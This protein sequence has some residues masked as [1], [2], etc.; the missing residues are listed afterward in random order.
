MRPLVLFDYD[1]VLVDSLDYFI[2]AFLDACHEHGCHQVRTR[3]DFLNLFDINFYDGMAKVGLTG[4][5]R[6]AVYRGMAERLKMKSGKYSFFKGIPEALREAAEFAD[7]YVI[8]SNDSRVVQEFLDA[9]N[10]SLYR[11][12][13]GA[14]KD[15]SK[16]RKIRGVS[17]RHPNVPAIYVGDTT[18]DILEARE[19]G[20]ISVGVAWGWHGLARLE[21]IRP[22]HLLKTPADLVPCLRTFISALPLTG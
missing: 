8:S 14:D 4:K 13:L 11:E 5:L 18:G 10:L 21:K 22:D 20:V 1:G 19:A 2:D 15:T 6:H 3:D 12:V 7:I 17:S 9:H 16:V